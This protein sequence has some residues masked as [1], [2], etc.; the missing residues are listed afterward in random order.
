MRQGRASRHVTEVKVEPT[1]HSIVPAGVAQ[2]GQAQGNHITDQ[3]HTGYHGVNPNAGRGFKAPMDA[4]RQ[5]HK[6]GSQGRR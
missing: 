6:S 5:V 3:G 1:P 2:L 4:G